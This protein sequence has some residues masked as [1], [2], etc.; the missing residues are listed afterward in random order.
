[1]LK[2]LI[3]LISFCSLCFSLVSFAIPKPF[4]FFFFMLAWPKRWLFFCHVFISLM[5]SLTMLK[6]NPCSFITSYYNLTIGKSKWILPLATFLLQSIFVLFFFCVNVFFIIGI[7]VCMYYL[8]VC[9][10]AFLSLVMTFMICYKTKKKHKH[11][12]PYRK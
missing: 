9:V 12:C 2:T 10:C 7:G 8:W 11:P 6:M 1:M 3:N 5:D 4:I